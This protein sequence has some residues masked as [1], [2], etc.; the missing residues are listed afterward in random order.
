[1]GLGKSTSI[2]YGLVGV[3]YQINEALEETTRKDYPNLPVAM[4][5]SGLINSVA[6]SLW[7]NDLGRFSDTEWLLGLFID[8]ILD[9]S[10][11]NILFGGVDT[12]KFEDPLMRV[13]I[14]KDPN[15]GAFDHF[16]VALTSVSASSSSG[17]DT[18]SSSQFPILTV[19]DS[20]TTL[21]YLPT[22]LATAIWKEVGAVIVDS[23][24]LGKIAAVPC[25]HSGST[26]S[27]IFGF[28]GPDGPQISVDMTELVVDMS[29]GGQRPT[30]SSRS[31]YPGQDACVFGIQEFSQSPY[32]LGDTFLRSAYVVYDLSNNEIGLAQ[33]KFNA[34]ASNV[35]PFPSRGAA[36]PS[37][38]VAPN[39]AE[40][41][42]SSTSGSSGFSASK[43][44]QNAAGMPATFDRSAMVVVLFGTFFAAVG[45]GLFFFV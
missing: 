20:G 26:G 36:I 42:G 18:L 11:G 44:F 41:S 22:D 25:S 21:S 43:G 45:S 32:L 12:N 30:F 6:Y 27:F 28:G 8:D 14:Q 9:A 35:V 38:T 3:G 40:I 39:Q 33:T 16:T 4:M 1:M 5:N 19:L 10:A 7:L 31:Q 23:E 34:S 24:D 15:V 37:S 2:A 29:S 17:N 13:S